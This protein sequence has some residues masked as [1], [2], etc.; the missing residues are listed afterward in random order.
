MKIF[1]PDKEKVTGSIEN[2]MMMS[3]MI[4]TPHQTLFG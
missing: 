3:F 1:A 2:C 4:C